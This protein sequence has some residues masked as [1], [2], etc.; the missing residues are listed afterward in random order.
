MIEFY[1]N[2]NPR[3]QKNWLEFGAPDALTRLAS[4]PP[5]PACGR[6]FSNSKGNRTFGFSSINFSHSRYNQNSLLLMLGEGLGMRVDSA[7]VDFVVSKEK[8][9][10]NWILLKRRFIA[11]IC[12]VTS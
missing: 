9:Q 4:S 3:L 5:S 1:C 11:P 7:M 6:G 8:V 12:K 2:K 10:F